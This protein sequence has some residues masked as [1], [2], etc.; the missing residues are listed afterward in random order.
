MPAASESPTITDASGTDTIS[1]A[2]NTPMEFIG[3]KGAKVATTKPIAKAAMC[4]LA[5]EW[6]ETLKFDE[7]FRQ[8]RLRGC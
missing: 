1:F 2:D 7:L 6:P 3:P 5:D 4:V 8:A